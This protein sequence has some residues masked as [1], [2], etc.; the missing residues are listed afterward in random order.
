MLPMTTTPDHDAVAADAPEDHSRMSFLEHLEELRRRIIYSLWGLLAGC[1][2]SAIFVDHFYMYFLKYLSDCI[3]NTL[4]ATEITEAFMFKF[5]LGFFGGFLLAS[6][7]IF[8]QLWLFVAPGL[9]LREKKI[10]IPFVVSASVLFGAGVWF[11]HFMAFPAMMKYFSSLGN[12]YLS[13]QPKI[14]AAWSTYVKMDLGMGAVFEMPMLVFFLARF[15]IVTWQFLVG[16]WRYAILGIFILAAIIT[17]SPDFVT[18]FVFAAPMV[19]LYGLSIGV[20]WMFGKKKKA[21]TI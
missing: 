5:K 10:V 8:S 21:A 3:H 18:Q 20:A 7:F 1:A 19:V 16:K 2:V 17:P 13:V 11:N 6:P 9:Y 4:L 14:S 15:G 12:Q